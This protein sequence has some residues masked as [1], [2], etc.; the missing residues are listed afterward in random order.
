VVEVVLTDITSNIAITIKKAKITRLY[1]R[2]PMYCISNHKFSVTV[3]SRLSSKNRRI[4]EVIA[5]DV[6]KGIF[7]TS[8]IPLN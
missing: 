5:P 2:F 1:S 3:A 6:F 4:Y 8:N 7:V